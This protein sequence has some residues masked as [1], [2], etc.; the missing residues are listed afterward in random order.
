MEVPEPQVQVG[1]QVRVEQ[2]VLA[3]H[4]DLRV[5]TVLV[6]LQGQVVQTE[7]VDHQELAVLE[8]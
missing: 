7:Q 5:Q 1:L 2:M 3:V 4:Q 6:E 8:F